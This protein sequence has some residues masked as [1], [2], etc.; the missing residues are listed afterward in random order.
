MQKPICDDC[1]RQYTCQHHMIR[2]NGTINPHYPRGNMWN[3][4]GSVRCF[5]PKH[6]NYLDNCEFKFAK[7]LG[8]KYM[9]YLKLCDT[10]VEPS[11]SGKLNKED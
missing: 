7:F 1:Y 11:L 3:K 4:D 9:D 6:Y 10:G 5:V 8:L 2:I